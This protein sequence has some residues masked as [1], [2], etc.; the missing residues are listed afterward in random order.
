MTVLDLNVV[1]FNDDSS[2]VPPKSA[3]KCWEASSVGMENFLS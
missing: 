1:F 2:A 3:A